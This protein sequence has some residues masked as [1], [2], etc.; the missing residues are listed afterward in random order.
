MLNDADHRTLT[1]IETGLRQ[2]DPAFVQRFSDTEWRRRPPTRGGEIMRTWLIIGVLAVCFA[3]L[4]KNAL[5]VVVGLSA[6]SVG[7]TWWAVPVDIDDQSPR[8]QRIPR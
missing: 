2:D 4:L 3:W 6:I 5:L 7:I 1:E 8:H